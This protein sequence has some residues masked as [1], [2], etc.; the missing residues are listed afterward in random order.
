[1]RKFW[2]M[3]SEKDYAP[4]LFSHLS[5]IL[6][7]TRKHQEPSAGASQSSKDDD[8]D[9]EDTAFASQEAASSHS[10]SVGNRR[11]AQRQ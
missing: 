8:G 5:R 1:M 2:E 9:D 6:F 7:M 4:N 10:A 11:R 3:T